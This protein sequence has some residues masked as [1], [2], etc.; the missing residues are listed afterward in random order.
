MKSSHTPKLLRALLVVLEPAR[1]LFV[2][3]QR[4]FIIA[5]V[6]IL[7]VGN[8]E[9]FRLLGRWLS[10]ALQ[11]ALD[12]IASDLIFGGRHVPCVDVDVGVGGLD[13]IG[14]RCW[15]QNFGGVAASA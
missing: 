14:L 5:A 4:S 3:L 15:S 7:I 1:I 8:V 12:T 10:S 11:L 6:R 13:Q 2:D 9:Q